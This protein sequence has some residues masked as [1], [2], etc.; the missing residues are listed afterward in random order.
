MSK[1]AHCGLLYTP[2]G[3][4]LG[5]VGG[6]LLIYGVYVGYGSSD[7]KEVLAEIWMI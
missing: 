5:K 2:W 4:T 6:G 3:G 1:A 7:Y